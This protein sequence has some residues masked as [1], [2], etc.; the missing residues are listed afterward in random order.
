MGNEIGFINYTEY[1][2]VIQDITLKT[3]TYNNIINL[4]SNSINAEFT[5]TSI[6]TNTNT[7]KF[8]G[9]LPHF[10]HII[11]YYHLTLINFIKSNYFYI[12]LVVVS[13]TIHSII[14]LVNNIFNGLETFIINNFNYICKI[15]GKMWKVI[16]KRY[17]GGWYKP[18]AFWSSPN[19]E[20]TEGIYWIKGINGANGYD[21]WK[22]RGK[23]TKGDY[24]DLNEE[25][26]GDVNVINVANSGGNGGGGDKDRGGW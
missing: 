22:Y 2:P 9:N 13:F 3:P 7:N 15:I 12:V 8:S 18:R 19:N 24:E 20:I 10:N 5:Q 25:G 11:W 26:S 1:L 6:S 4:P 16:K 17:N 21:E 23:G 14:N